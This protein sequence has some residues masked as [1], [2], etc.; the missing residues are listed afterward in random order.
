MKVLLATNFFKGS[1]SAVDAAKVIKRSILREDESIKI[2]IIPISDG[3]DGTIEAIKHCTDCDE[4]VSSVTG[5][6]GEKVDAKWLVI[7]RAKE[8]IAIIEGAQANGLSLLKPCQYNPLVTT[9]MGIG[10]LILL[11]LEKKCKK[12]IVTIGGS[13]TNDCGTGMLN[14]LGAKLYDKSGKAPEPGGGPLEKL[15]KID[16]EGLDNRLKSV[17]LVVACDVDN[18][19]C[20]P[21][22]ASAIYGPQKG[23]TPEMVKFLDRNLAKFADIVS[24]NTGQ[25]LRDYPGVG[26]AG[27][28]GYAMKAVLGAELIPGFDL[29]AEL[30]SMEDKIKGVNLVITTEGRL[31]SQSL[32]G[33]APFQVAKLAKKY[34]IPA[35]VIAG[36]VE[37]N[38]DL[39]KANIT[40]AFSIVDGPISLE[41]AMKN[42]EYLLD[43][44]TRQII[45]LVKI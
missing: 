9:T 3:G 27:G 19:L 40:S 13:S 44:I 5:P 1:L 17:K 11:A 6:L 36:S 39:K 2:D 29:V 42:A 37:R 31:D 24:L 38:L 15:E 26:A 32:S 30:S 16:L 8:K 14:A 41:D 18:P 45:N 10:E 35:I 7:T 12:I 43:N 28:I 34:D 20:G 22:G 21:N 33:K 4:I 25:D 23:A